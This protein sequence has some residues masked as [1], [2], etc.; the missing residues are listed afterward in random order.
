MKTEEQVLQLLTC[1]K[2]GIESKFS[3]GL[4]EPCLIQFYIV[5]IQYIFV[6]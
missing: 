1:F 6:K 4:L 5:G 3:L 2:V